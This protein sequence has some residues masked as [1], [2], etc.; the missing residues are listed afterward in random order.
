MK[1]LGISIAELLWML[2]DNRSCVHGA[3]VLEQSFKMGEYMTSY[4]NKPYLRDFVTKKNQRYVEITKYV[5]ETS[6]EI[7]SPD[8]HKALNLSLQRQY[9]EKVVYTKILTATVTG[10]NSRT[11]CWFLC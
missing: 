6:G 2:H 7:L 8:E 10:F 5:H 1:T 11:R 3:A 4:L 9:E